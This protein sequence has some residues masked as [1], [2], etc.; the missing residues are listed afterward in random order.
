MKLYSLPQ[1]DTTAKNLKQNDKPRPL[2]YIF[3]ILFRMSV[4][5]SNYSDK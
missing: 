5:K 3:Y 4:H 1:F 2:R